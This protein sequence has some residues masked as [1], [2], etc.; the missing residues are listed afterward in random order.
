MGRCACVSR[1]PVVCDDGRCVG[2][3]DGCVVTL[4]AEKVPTLLLVGGPWSRGAGYLASAPCA[5][6]L[7][8]DADTA[9]GVQVS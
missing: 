8:N 4:M 1:V 9:H 7:T 5:G 3:E 6:V 2:D